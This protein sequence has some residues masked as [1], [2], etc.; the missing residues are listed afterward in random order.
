MPQKLEAVLTMIRN[1]TPVEKIDQEI[2]AIGTALFQ[3]PP[4]LAQIRIADCQTGDTKRVSSIVK[5]HVQ[6]DLTGTLLGIT[7]RAMRTGKPQL[8]NDVSRDKEY[9]EISRGVRSELAIPL[10]LHEVCSGVINFETPNADWFTEDD[11]YWG[12]IL[13]QLVAL[14][15]QIDAQRTRQDAETLTGIDAEGMA[16]TR[17]LTT[18]LDDTLRVLNANIPA[19]DARFMVEVLG[20]ASENNQLVTLMLRPET[21]VAVHMRVREGEGIIGNVFKTKRPFI[22]PVTPGS[23]D[24][25]HIQST[26]SAL[27]FPLID[28]DGQ[29]LGILN[30]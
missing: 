12:T 20:V 24:N 10:Q 7:G 3:T 6:D 15:D 16:L 29:R 1:E 2:L 27:V 23:V 26:R 4:E 13:A 22:G 14:A 5:A 8:V 21:S 11:L 25:T 17:D 9:H 30:V 19:D 18:I 28:A